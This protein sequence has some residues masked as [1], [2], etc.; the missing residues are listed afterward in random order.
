M[1]HDDDLGSV[2]SYDIPCIDERPGKR[3]SQNCKD[4]KSNI[5]AISD[6]SGGLGVDVLTKGDLN[7]SAILVRK[8]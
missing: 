4:K 7:M 3:R 5:S 6:G 2:R 8:I 1:L